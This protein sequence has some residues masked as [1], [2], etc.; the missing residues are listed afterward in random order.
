M[1]SGFAF[2]N[3][4]GTVDLVLSSLDGAC[5][6]AKGAKVHAGETLVQLFALTGTAPGAF[7]SANKDVKYATVAATCASGTPV[8][9]GGAVSAS[10]RA[11]TSTVTISSLTASGAQ[12][13]LDLVFDDGSKASGSFDVPTCTATTFENAVCF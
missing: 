7:T 4:D 2:K 8:S 12:G 11:T 3:A 13:T 6:S 1:K 10:G 5:D 9:A